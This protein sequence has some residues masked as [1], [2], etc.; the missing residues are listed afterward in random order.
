MR[1]AANPPPV[2]FVGLCSMVPVIA[3]RRASVASPRSAASTLVAGGS[4]A[5]VEIGTIP[6]TAARTSSWPYGS[7]SLP[8][9]SRSAPRAGAAPS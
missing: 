9:T 8:L 2:V 1:T 6:P 3:A 7:A 4:D 5:P